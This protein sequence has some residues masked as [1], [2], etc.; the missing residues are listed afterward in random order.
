MEPFK[1]PW[2]LKIEKSSDFLPVLW[3]F[4]QNLT[5]VEIRFKTGSKRSASGDSQDP[6]MAHSLALMA[7]NGRFY[8]Q[9]MR[10][11]D[12]S[13]SLTQS[14]S[15]SKRSFA[16]VA[17]SSSA[18]PPPPM[19]K[20]W[21]TSSSSVAA[22]CSSSLS[23]PCTVIHAKDGVS[24]ESFQFFL[25]YIY[26]VKNGDDI[27][28]SVA[29]GLVDLAREY[30]CRRLCLDLE[31]FFIR[32]L[33]QQNLPERYEVGRTFE[34]H[35]LV[36]KCLNMASSSLA[37]FENSELRS[38]ISKELMKDILAMD[39]L[40]LDEE[41]LFEFFLKWTSEVIPAECASTVQS[42]LKQ[43]LRF[44]SMPVDFLATKVDPTG[45]LTKEE[46]LS[47]AFDATCSPSIPKRSGFPSK[48]RKLVSVVEATCARRGRFSVECDLSTPTTLRALKQKFSVAM[49][50][51]T[52][53]LMFEFDMKDGAFRRM[54]NPGLSLS[55]INVDDIE[56]D[57]IDTSTLKIVVMWTI[58]AEPSVFGGA[59]LTIR[60][61]P[62]ATIGHLQTKVSQELR[63][64]SPTEVPPSSVAFIT[65]D[66]NHIH[67]DKMTLTEANIAG[68]DVIKYKILKFKSE[69]VSF[70]VT[71]MTGE[72]ATFKMKRS[73]P[74]KKLKDAYS[75]KYNIRDEEKPYCR[76]LY[77]GNRINDDDTPDSFG[78]DDG[79]VI[80]FFWAPDFDFGARKKS[81]ANTSREQE[82]E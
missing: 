4:G 12:Q 1:I 28:E 58:V 44:P 61:H 6:L 71:D 13:L 19:A 40:P 2:Q 48:K 21:M 35:H 73:T 23:R 64:T 51:P 17:S 52:E 57:L 26:F 42:S 9:L 10:C 49:A 50:L 3:R 59:K 32:T 46:L 77:D 62:D 47:V 7:L 27:S 70:N 31:N 54:W 82:L 5:D 79:D 45:V 55:Q 53:V 8:D 30:D 72:T 37:L 65:P 22:T 63:L 41:K 15:G 24:R 39:Q 29:S 81:G 18:S 78:I 74:L 80:E 43:H 20:R 16:N 33:N 67:D 56:L 25:E 11:D 76:F 14:T 68:E 69:Q 60:I 66:G 34:F 75:E 36:L 38:R